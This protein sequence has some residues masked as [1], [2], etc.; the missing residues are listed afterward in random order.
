MRNPP[1]EPIHE[2]LIDDRLAM[3]LIRNRRSFGRRYNAL[4][5][6]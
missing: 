6:A 3:P 1:G 4:S 5:P 2:Y